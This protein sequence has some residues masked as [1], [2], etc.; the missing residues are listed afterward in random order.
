VARPDTSKAP[1]PKSLAVLAA[2]QPREPRRRKAAGV[3]FSLLAHGAALLAILYLHHDAPMQQTGAD[4]P[5]MIASLVDGVT[6]T[7]APAATPEAQ[8]QPQ[9]A[10]APKTKSFVRKALI[11]REDDDA[12]EADEEPAPVLTSAQLAS[13]ST[14]ESGG[15]GG[16]GQ[17]AAGGGGK[18]CNMA[19]LL[20]SALRRDAHVQSAIAQSRQSA[21]AMFVWNGD[22][23]RSSGQDGKGLAALREA[24]LWEVG[25]APEACR[26]TPVHGLV[27]ISLHDGPGSPRIVLGQGNWRWQ[28]ILG[29]RE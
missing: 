21:Q 10:K 6:Q 13:A 7:P 29:V 28:D 15:A 11:P 20:Q 24:I 14:A 1:E 2:Q 18:H 5:M 26:K 19:Q 8:P 4:G 25:F 17:G 12:L 22:W 3:V 9:P 16:A 23:V 27:M